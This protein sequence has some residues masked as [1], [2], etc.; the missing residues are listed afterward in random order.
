MQELDNVLVV[1]SRYFGGT[2]LGPDRYAFSIE[3]YISFRLI[4]PEGSNI[5]TNVPGMRSN[6]GVF[7][8]TIKYRG[9]EENNRNG[10]IEFLLSTGVWTVL[11][12]PVPADTR[13]LSEIEVLISSYEVQNL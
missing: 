3:C 13:D 7:W 8:H 10:E 9:K 5:S 6:W 1:V 2:H 11:R 4:I 12:V